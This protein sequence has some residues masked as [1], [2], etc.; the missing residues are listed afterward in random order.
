MKK[1][2]EYIA[3]FMVAVFTTVS[4]T[5]LDEVVYS[6]MP[7]DSYGTIEAEVNSLMAPVFTGLRDFPNAMRM[8][9]CSS[10]M[11]ITPTRKGG[12]WWDGG[13][14]KELRFG[15]WTP[16]TSN[17]R[18]FYN[19]CMSK[20]TSCN[21]ILYMIGESEAIADKDP[22]TSQ[23]RAARAFWYIQL[24]DLYGNVP[25]VSDFT[26]VT[27]PST[28]PRKDV[29]AFIM[30]ELNDIKDIIRSDVSTSSYGKFTK[31]AVYSMLAKMYL[32]ANVWN[33]DGGTKWQEC[34][35]AC[36]VVMDLGYKLQ[37]VW[38]D[39][40]IT[41]NE[42]STETILPAVYST[43]SGF[44]C[45]GWTLHYLDPI[46]LGLSRNCSNGIAAMPDYV[47]A[48]DPDD[49]RLNGSFLLG[50]MTNPATGAILI[51]AHG[52][53]LIHTADIT[54]KY[55]IDTDGWGQVEQEDGGRI[56]K[57]E[58]KKGLSTNNENDFAIYRLADIYLMKAEC[59]IRLGENNEEA[60]RL[61]NL[62][63]ARA[64][65]DASKLKASVTL[66]DIYQERRFEFAWEA[67]TRQDQIRFGTF[68]N[69]IPGWRGAIPEKCLLMP[70]P[71]TAINANPNLVQNPGY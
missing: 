10:D 63:R 70:I 33:P 59:L 6:Q 25:I 1:L 9:E 47:K 66:D 14:Y 67:M 29:Y 15:T 58:Y 46:A 62:I 38:K 40:F 3:L 69:A 22:Y 27:M 24:C 34:I 57:W 32:N 60:T 18:S 30:S 21:Q 13:Q 23:I 36:N 44:G 56:Y 5:D 50:P 37:T 8:I 12:D 2:I 31:G 16:Q 71:Q 49:K 42:S 19:T 64:F 28:S 20:I 41:N 54:I 61:V 26:D 4:C 68:L 51:T 35:D 55:N 11:A 52:R 45:V 7:M 65:T 53:E 43:T 48:F 17:I 39:N